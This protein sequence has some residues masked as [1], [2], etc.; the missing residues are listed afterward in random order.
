MQCALLNGSGLG[1]V[2]L[3]GG[4]VLIVGGG[5]GV[6]GIEVVGAG[7][8]G[9]GALVGTVSFLLAS[10]ACDV[11]EKSAVPSRG[12]LNKCHS[13]GCCVVG[14][15]SA[16]VGSVVLVVWH[17]TLAT[18]EH[19]DGMVQVFGAFVNSHS[20]IVVEFL[21]EL[22]G[23][24]KVGCTEAVVA[25]EASVSFLIQFLGFIGVDVQ[26]VSIVVTQLEAFRSR[27]DCFLHVDLQIGLP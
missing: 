22:L 8:G 17:G 11:I 27:L 7:A 16:P 9:F 3:C 20:K 15:A 24:V 13:V 14:V 1:G 6:S 21:A 10:V 25:L 23:L 5:L 19:S 4:M 18:V 2:V 26:W 12:C